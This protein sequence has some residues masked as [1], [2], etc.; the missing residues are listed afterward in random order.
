MSYSIGSDSSLIHAG[1]M[2]PGRDNIDKNLPIVSGSEAGK[3]TNN[4][5]SLTTNYSPATLTIISKQGCKKAGLLFGPYCVDDEGNVANFAETEIVLRTKDF[6]IS[7]IQTRGNV[8]LFWKLESNL[9]TTKIEFPRSEE[10]S[11]HAFDRHFDSLNSNYGIVHVL[12]ALSSRGNQR[13]LSERYEAAIKNQPS[14]NQ[15]NYTKVEFSTNWLKSLNANILPFVERIK[16]PLK[17]YDAYCYDYTQ[18][19]YIARQSGLFMVNTLDSND[20][21][22][23]IQSIISQ[24]IFELFLKDL[25]FKMTD[26]F[27]KAHQYLWNANGSRLTNLIENYTSN[28]TAN[29]SGGLV[30]A[31]A[32]KSKQYMN[33]S[34]SNVSVS[35]RHAIDKLLGRTEKQF[36]VL[37]YDPIHDFVTEELNKRSD[38]YTQ[39]NEITI[40]TGTFNVNA[41]KYDGDLSPWIFPKIKDY[42]ENNRINNGDSNSNNNN[43]GG[44]VTPINSDSNNNS[45]NSTSDKGHSGDDSGEENYNKENHGLI[46]D[47]EIDN[48]K[49]K[50]MEEIEKIN[51]YH[52]YDIISIGL[53][54][55]VE[56]SAN[57]M[58][59][60]DPAS[61]FFWE[62]KIKDVLNNNKNK[63][64]NQNHNK[65]DYVL[66]R[67]EQ[68]GG[69]ILLIFVKE[70]H[71][72]KIKNVRGSVKKTGFGGIVPFSCWFQ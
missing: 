34:N 69:I 38:E 41:V 2:H 28:R 46:E 40:F 45:N 33:S 3:N 29:K 10:S 44:V 26:E 11:Q 42:N 56:L 65:N 72:E 5:S 6:L 32:G 19:S 49:I 39:K 25:N 67:S 18:H 63:S 57:K 31:V 68:L 36:M 53:E 1:H 51:K 22:N 16:E 37:L 20:K 23:L 35:K 7:F 50:L 70:I 43:G 52:D 61:R 13:D 15:I 48:E 27:W 62:K 12:D 14:T 21:A 47:A 8:P 71:S 64:I 60:I 59:N 17:D 58:M 24:E 54:E 55:I 66:L 9:M 4:L 30:G